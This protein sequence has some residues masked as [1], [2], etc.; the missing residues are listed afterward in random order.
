MLAERLA[1]HTPTV[2][3]TSL[4]PK[5]LETGRL[6][7]DT[8]GIPMETAAGLHEHDRGNVPFLGSREQFETQ[9][10]GLFEHPGRLVYGS[11]TADQAHRRFAHGI[12]SVLEEHPSG[13]L[14][15][16]THGTVLTLFVARVTG[17][18]P[19]PFWQQLGLP[20]FVVLSLPELDLLL[21]EAAIQT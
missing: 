14:A 18:D 8:L 11:E 9:V 10:A 4:E 16:V 20:S 13:N 1:A 15:V 6:V 19:V 21:V 17:I 12:T 3:V 7:A 5:A 2:I